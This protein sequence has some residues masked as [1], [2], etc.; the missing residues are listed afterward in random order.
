[1]KFIKLSKL[2]LIMGACT[3]QVYASAISAKSNN[4]LTQASDTQAVSEN[5]LKLVQ[6]DFISKGVKKDD[7]N[8]HNKELAQSISDYPGVVWKIWTVNEQTEEGGGIYLFNNDKSMKS[9]LKMH[10]KRLKK[11]GVTDKV[12]VKIFEIPETL[13]QITR[14][15]LSRNN[16]MPITTTKDIS[17]MRL[18]QM[19]FINK[20][21]GKE[22]MDKSFHGLAQSI[23]EYPGVIWKIWT[24]NDKTKEGGGIYLFEDE[25]SMKSYL[26]MHTKRL[27]DNGVTD[28]INVK[29]FEIPEILTRIDFGPIPQ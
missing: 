5:K 19:D 18:V 29:V 25:S 28:K 21:P 17:D 24:V 1:M 3:L 9:Y 14:G 27:K 16:S 26:E 8:K 4:E 22:E 7:M 2:M 11:F 6:M 15:K 12:N 20:G 10:T 13:T 23:A